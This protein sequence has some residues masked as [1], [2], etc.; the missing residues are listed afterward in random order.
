MYNYYDT[1]DSL[2]LS[3][4]LPFIYLFSSIK[5][6]F[7]IYFVFKNVFN[8]YLSIYD[9]TKIYFKFITSIFI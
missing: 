9:V 4:Y 8:T 2:C 3:N 5:T 6:Y 7:T 1:V